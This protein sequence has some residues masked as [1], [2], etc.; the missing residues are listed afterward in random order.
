MQQRRP[1]S[2]HIQAVKNQQVMVWSVNTGRAGLAPVKRRRSRQMTHSSPNGLV[3][4]GGNSI[5]VTLVVVVFHVSQ[6]YL[7]ERP[8]TIGRW[9]EGGATHD[10][11]HN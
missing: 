2:C 5:R 3:A 6:P 11:R 1:D 7:Q 10:L 4:V 8:N 9:P